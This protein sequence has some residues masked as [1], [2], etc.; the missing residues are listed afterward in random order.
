MTVGMGGGETEVFPKKE[1]NID[2]EL[3]YNGFASK[4]VETYARKRVVTHTVRQTF[5]FPG[6]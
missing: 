4:S 3:Y 6:L 1:G 2:V 5:G